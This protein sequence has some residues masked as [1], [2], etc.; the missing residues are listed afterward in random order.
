[1]LVGLTSIIMLL[2]GGGELTP[3]QI[4]TRSFPEALLSSLQSPG[5]FHICP[6]L[7]C[8][9]LCFFCVLYSLKLGQPYLLHLKS[10]LLLFTDSSNKSFLIKIIPNFSRIL[11][12]L[13]V[14]Q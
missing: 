11:C 2:G 13:N 14:L 12:G 8:L 10:T 6:V 5:L 7:L 4:P 3:R 1:M 9:Y